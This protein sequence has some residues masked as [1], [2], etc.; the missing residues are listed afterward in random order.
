M[1]YSFSFGISYAHI[2][3]SDTYGRLW[4]FSN[5]YGIFRYVQMLSHAIHVAALV[6]SHDAKATQLQF[7]AIGSLHHLHIFLGEDEDFQDC[8]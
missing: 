8:H 5:Y 3:F 4:I 6:W 1:H 2:V 7:I